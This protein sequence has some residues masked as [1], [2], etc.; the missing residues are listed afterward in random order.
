MSTSETSTGGLLADPVQQTV[1]WREEE[2]LRH[3][4]PIVTATALALRPDIDLH[5]ACD[6]LDNGCTPRQLAEILL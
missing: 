3:G 5:K 2:L 4:C 6:M 1:D